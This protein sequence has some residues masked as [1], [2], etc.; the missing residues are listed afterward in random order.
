[1]T[2]QEAYEKIREYF[3]RP[4]AVL[5]KDINTGDCY[6]SENDRKCAVGCL[7]P[8]YL[9]RRSYEV[10]GSIEHL[11][12][13]LEEEGNARARK[14]L[15]IIDGPGKENEKKFGF[16]VCAQNLHDASDDV[17]T[18]LGLLNLHARNCELVV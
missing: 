8:D 14:V 4:G 15:D 10:A 5:G 7:I 2:T 13:F 16:L 12:V 11:R 6:Y 3:N 17:P 9:Y 1:M 18:F